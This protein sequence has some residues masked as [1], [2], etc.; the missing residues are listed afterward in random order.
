MKNNSNYEKISQKEEQRFQAILAM[1]KGQ[2]LFEQIS[3]NNLIV[4]ELLSHC[5]IDAIHK[6]ST[7][8]T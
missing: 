5:D 7:F 2:P 8:A 6:R 1:L 4:R 3:T